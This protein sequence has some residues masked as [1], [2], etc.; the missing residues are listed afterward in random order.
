[1][2]SIVESGRVDR[3]T[4]LVGGASFAVGGMFLR[5]SAAAASAGDTTWTPALVTG[6]A[7]RDAVVV[8]SLDT[9]RRV[10]VGLGPG[11]IVHTD[12]SAGN[13]ILIEGDDG[14]DGSIAARRVIRGVF[15]ERSDVQR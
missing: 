15:G 2:A 10:Q 9:H 11:T 5:T 3:R 6:Q 12:L 4:L 1:M 14:L 13:Q 7:S 8:T